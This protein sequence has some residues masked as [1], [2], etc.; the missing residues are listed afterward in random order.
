MTDVPS[1]T[2]PAALLLGLVFGAGACNVACLPFLGP[3]LMARDGGVRRAWRTVLPFSLGRLAGYSLLGGGAGLLGQSAELWLD[4]AVARWLLGGAAVAA[5]IALLV[6]SRRPAACAS[7]EVGVRPLTDMRRPPRVAQP[8]LPGALFFMGAGMALNPA[9][10]PLALIV[11]AAAATASAGA[12][13]ALGMSFGAGAVV[14]PFL[15]FGVLVAHLGAELR[16][17]VST[18]QT[19][20][21][22]TAAALLIVLGALTL[23]P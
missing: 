8:A 18:W 20:L 12:G 6:R 5:G 3:V 4:A 15:V 23:L 21:E 16:R 22:R 2:L 7:A 9:C 1:L 14:V 17:H 11:A 13:L 19:A 10:G